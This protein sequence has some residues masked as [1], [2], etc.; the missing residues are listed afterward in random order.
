M[1]TLKTLLVAS[2]LVAVVAPAKAQVSGGYAF[3]MPIFDKAGRAVFNGIPA[4]R[5][6]QIYDFRGK[7]VGRVITKAL[8]DGQVISLL[9]LH[10]GCTDLKSAEVALLAPN[11]A[12]RTKC[13]LLVPSKP[14]EIVE[15][16][17]M[18]MVGRNA[19]SVF[20]LRP[21]K[22][23][24]TCRW[25]FMYFQRLYTSPAAF[26]RTLEV[27]D[28]FQISEKAAPEYR[29]YNLWTCVTL[30]KLRSGNHD[31]CGAPAHGQNFEVVRKDS[32]A[33][34]YRNAGSKSEECGWAVLKPEALVQEN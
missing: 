22:T 31:G 8:L 18:S 15:D 14:Y 21:W 30:E 12:D 32:D 6:T 10:I 11:N 26:G 17:S 25:V 19:P 23:E 33:V 7:Y 9:D 3:Q 16:R 27:G 34:C 5:D 1:T 2:A 28:R 20:C 4:G 13:E 29:A 24:T